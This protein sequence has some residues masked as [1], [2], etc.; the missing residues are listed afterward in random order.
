M[1]D[2]H[3]KWRRMGATLAPGATDYTTDPMTNYT[4]GGFA[5][6]YY[7]DPYGCWPYLFRPDFDFNNT[8]GL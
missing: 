5:G 4:A 3:A 7:Q 8:T 6:D 1:D 2:T